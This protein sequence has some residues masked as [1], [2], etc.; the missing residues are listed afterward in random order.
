MFPPKLGVHKTGSSSDIDKRKSWKTI[1]TAQR[2]RH[3][4]LIGRAVECH[5]RPRVQIKN[6]I[7]QFYPGSKSVVGDIGAK[8]ERGVV[9]I[10]TVLERQHRRSGLPLVLAH[11]PQDIVLGERWRP[12]AVDLVSIQWIEQV[13]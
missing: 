2:C 11:A 7:G 8:H 10:V 5:D 4:G 9:A 12:I 6:R 13:I 1:I 3:D